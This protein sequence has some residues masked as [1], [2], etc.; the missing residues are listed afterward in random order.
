MRVALTGRGGFTGRFVAAALLRQGVECVPIE[1]NLCD[2]H[3]VERAVGEADFDRIIHLAASAFVGT[4]DWRGFYEVNQLGT[5][6]LLDAVARA[7]PG[8]RC[9]LASSAQVY[10]PGA[11]GLIAEDA[12]TRPANHYAISKLAMEQGAALWGDRLEIVVTRPFN[13]TGIGQGG[14][15]LLPKI[16]NHFRR[17]AD[18][19]ELGNTWVKRDF[20]DVRA[21]ADA[22]AGL[23]LTDAPP[24]LTN[25]ATGIVW[26]IDEILAILSDLSGHRPEIR[27]NPAFVRANDVAVLGGDAYRLRAALPGWAPRDLSNTLA[28]MYA[29]DS[30]R[31]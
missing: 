17:R 21:V 30:D 23:V 5:Q 18:V 8:A 27:V 7:R 28:W 2:R 29:G 1:A 3:A 13:Y 22:Y 25:I 4:A 12:P 14:E 10:G 19:I 26:S 11:E 31:D 15:Y 9:I 24:A 16:V 20:G 6:T